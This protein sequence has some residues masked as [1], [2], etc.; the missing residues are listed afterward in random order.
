MYFRIFLFLTFIFSLLISPIYAQQL[1]L[2]VDGGLSRFVGQDYE[3]F[4]WGFEVGGHLMFYL[5]DNVLLGIRGAYNRATP[6]DDKF[7]INNTTLSSKDVEG[8]AWVVE[9]IPTIRLT[10][11]YP[12]SLVNFFAQAG[13]GLYV[14]SNEITVSGQTSLDSS[15]V[16][17]IFG[18]SSR[19]R[20]GLQGGAGFSFGSPD[21]ATFDVFS[22]FN[23]I[24]TDNTTRK[25]FTINLGLSFNI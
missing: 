13:A 19:G 23:L 3:R 22:L 18:E 4:N 14:L 17:Q 9:A 21:V 16:T 1:K 25:Y 20:F 2:S 5:D 6:E 8:S 11:N 10:T 7:S 24:F 15:A 12:M